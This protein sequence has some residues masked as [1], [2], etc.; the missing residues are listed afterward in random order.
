M[1]LTIKLVPEARK[2]AVIEDVERGNRAGIEPHPF[3]TDTC[4]GDWHYNRKRFVD[5]S[6]MPA[7][8]VIHRLC[9]VVAKNGNLMLSVPMRGD[10]TIDSEERRIVTEIGAWLKLYGDAIFATRPWKVAGEGP[11]QVAS[12]QFVDG[13]PRLSF[14]AKDIR[15]TT[16]GGHLYAITLDK[17]EP[18]VVI[19]SLASAKVTRVTIAGQTAPLAF[20]VDGKALHVTLPDN[21]RHDIGIALKISGRGLLA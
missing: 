20:H 3:Q 8:D 16:K 11:T 9:D 1:A 12:G 18:V 21:A 6:Y 4:L 10:G 5:K 13:D 14:T 15:F 7:R 17:P 19:T 2:A